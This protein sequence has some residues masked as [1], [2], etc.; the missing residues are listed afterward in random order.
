MIA[1]SLDVA[2]FDHW[3]ELYVI[4][5]RRGSAVSELVRLERLF[6]EE[7]AWRVLFK[8]ARGQMAYRRMMRRRI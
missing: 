8:R 1:F 6:G 2:S 7:A 4:Y 5:P 3:P